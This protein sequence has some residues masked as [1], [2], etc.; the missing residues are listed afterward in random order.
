MAC[1]QNLINLKSDVGQRFVQQ[2]LHATSA[3]MALGVAGE[4]PYQ[5]IHRVRWKMSSPLTTGG[6]KPPRRAAV[7]WL[8]VYIARQILKMRVE[9]F[10]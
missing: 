7:I 9:P 2:T 10:K 8:L 4:P 6:S 5:R 3:N 1:V